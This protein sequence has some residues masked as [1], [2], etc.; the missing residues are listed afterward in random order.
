MSGFGV[1]VT[2]LTRVPLPRLPEDSHRLAGAVPWFPVVGALVGAAIAGI[3]GVASLGLPALPAATVAIGCGVLLTGALHEDGLGDSADALAGGW[4]REERLRILR[5]PG[6]G[7]YG[8]SAVAIS[9]LLR[10]SALSALDPWDAAA[11]LVAA[12]ALAR[13]AAAGLLGVLHPATDE[14]LGASYARAVTRGHVLGAVVV[15]A[16]VGS[17]AIGVLALPAFAVALAGAAYLGLTAR[18]KIGGLTGDVLGA[19][20]QIA[21]ALILLLAATAATTAWTT[22]SWWR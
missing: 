11:A 12:H 2:F 20:E 16:A 17:V 8:V 18:R 9:L 15:G 14:G 10:V 22:V 21:E 5:D 13:A 6:L 4:T 7:T 19:A 1:A 3:Y